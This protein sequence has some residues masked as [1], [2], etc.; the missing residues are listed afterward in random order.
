MIPMHLRIG[1]GTR[2]RR[3]LLNS[4][5]ETVHKADPRICSRMNRREGEEKQERNGGGWEV[6]R[7]TVTFHELSR[8]PPGTHAM[9]PFENALSTKD[10]KG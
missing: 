9:L 5:L 10:E 6:E 8:Y 1:M 2:S 7:E 3:A 4:C